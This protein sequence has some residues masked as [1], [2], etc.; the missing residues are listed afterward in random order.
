MSSRPAWSI[1]QDPG[2]LRLHRESLS[3]KKKKKKKKRKKE[4]NKK[5]KTI[6]S[7]PHVSLIIIMRILNSEKHANKMATS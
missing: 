6:H 1:D 7:F 4:K 5:E 2:Q 3:Q